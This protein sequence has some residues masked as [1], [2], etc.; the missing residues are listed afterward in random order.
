M[1][2]KRSTLVLLIF[3]CSCQGWSKNQTFK[4][5]DL[6]SYGIYG[7]VKCYTETSQKVN[8][9]DGWNCL[10]DTTE[11]YLITVKR[12][13]G[14]NGILD[15]IEY[16]SENNML[17]Q[18]VKYDYNNKNNIILFQYDKTGNEIKFSRQIS[19]KDSI[20]KTETID[21]KTKKTISV[22]QTK[23]KNKLVLWQK[24]K[25]LQKKLYS[26]YIYERNEK[27][28]ETQIKTIF[29]YENDKNENTVKI[30]YLE[31]DSYGNWIKRIEYNSDKTNCLL[32]TRVFT[33]YK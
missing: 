29:G 6:N 22:S 2:L 4:T 16:F 33:F 17:I 11:H 21:S 12:Y 28:L 7:K 25:E 9:K 18:T 3:L 14:N 10:H 20:L 24:S 1:N 31:F 8:C 30:V 27:G 32:K 5:T 19:F 23:Y 13:F 26:E 15:S